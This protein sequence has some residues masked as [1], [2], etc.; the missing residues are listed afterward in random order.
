M[1]GDAHATSHPSFT[2]RHTQPVIIP[3]PCAR[4]ANGATS[5]RMSPTRFLTFLIIG[6]LAGWLTGLVL[7][8]R[9]F[10]LAGNV[11]VGIIGAFLASFALGLLGISAH[12]VTGQFI[13]AVL[14][15][16][17]FVGVLRFIRR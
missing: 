5:P 2:S 15:S 8:G 13:F 16:V 9:G 7:K 11:I 10:G 17:V 6:G 14:G 12:S 1:G 3:C 4:P